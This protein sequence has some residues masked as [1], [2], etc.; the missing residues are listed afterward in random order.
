MQVEKKDWRMELDSFLMMYRTT[1][2]T[3]TGVSPA[4]LMFKR[5]LRTRIPGIEEHSVDDLEIRDR[6]SE[7]KAKGKMFADK[8]R[9]AHERQ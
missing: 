1:P 4:E 7:Q 6:D 2:H 9:N 3:V 5:K 8:R